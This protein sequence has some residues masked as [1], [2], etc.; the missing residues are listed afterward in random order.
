MKYIIIESIPRENEEP[1]VIPII[2][3]DVLVHAQVARRMC[4][5]IRM[6][7]KFTTTSVVSAGFYNPI[8]CTCSGESE[9]LNLKSRKEDSLIIKLYDYAQGKPLPEEITSVV[10][11]KLG[12]NSPAAAAIE[13]ALS[14]NDG[15][16]FLELWSQGE[17]DVLSCNWDDIPDSVFIGADPTC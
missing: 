17:F 15:L 2:F 5:S 10:L 14:N 11:T 7:H 12:H 4:H 8:D 6:D 3:P 16:E 9:S 13:Y 1:F